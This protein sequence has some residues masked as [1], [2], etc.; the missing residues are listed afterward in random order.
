MAGILPDENTR[1]AR[2]SSRLRNR[3]A[4]KD[5]M[6]LRLEETERD[7][8]E[9]LALYADFIREADGPLGIDL[10]ADIAAG[11]PADLIAPNGV[12]LLARGDDSEPAGLG[13]VRFLD[14]EAAEVKSMYVAPAFR[15]HGFA[16]AILAELE[17]IA[18]AR[19]CRR[20][21][22]DTSDY[23]TGA[24]ALYRGAGYREVA[25]YN[26][27]PKANLW[28]ERTL[29]DEPIRIAAYD[30][31]WPAR[32]E[33]ERELLQA[34]IGEWITG[35]IHHVGSTAVPGLAAKPTVDILAGVEG[36]EASTDCFEHL[37]RLEYRYAPYLAREMHWFCK[38]DP[39]RRRFHLHLVPSDSQRYRDE[40]AFRDRLRADPGIAES[41]ASLKRKLAAKHVDDRE[42]YTEAKAV[43][44]HCALDD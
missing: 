30:P 39:R 3:L 19:G 13:G 18:A 2:K 29:T 4:S 6:R 25:P 36:L 21:Q 32:F 16:R 40:L 34:A 5:A 20:V 41:Y 8:P 15:G 1:V 11:P 7:R 28:F 23:L 33:A 9:V 26:R 24:I 38:P 37:A 35:G 22:L 43:F 14:T 44:I 10:G 12:L 17:R 31:G 42:A 27:N